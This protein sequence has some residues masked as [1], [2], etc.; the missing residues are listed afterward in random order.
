MTELRLA[1]IT[2]FVSAF[3]GAGLIIA[4]VAAYPMENSVIAEIE[5]TSKGYLQQ[6]S[7]ALSTSQ[8]LIMS[9]QASLQ[10]TK[11]TVNQALPSL[12][13]TVQDANSMVTLLDSLGSSF[14]EMGNSISLISFLSI[15]PFGDVGNSMKSVSS[16]IKQAS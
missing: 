9:T 16:S 5:S 14:E 12:S 1:L 6:S 15:S 2:G 8:K 11:N 13:N 3:F 10:Q 7:S 4:G